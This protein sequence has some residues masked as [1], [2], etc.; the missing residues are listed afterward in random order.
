MTQATSQCTPASKISTKINI[1]SYA[2]AFQKASNLDCP[3]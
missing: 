1:F 2:I 3:V